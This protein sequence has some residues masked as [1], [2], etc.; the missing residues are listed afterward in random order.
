[1]TSFARN[2]SFVEDEFIKGPDFEDEFDNIAD[3]LNGLFLAGNLSASSKPTI[4]PEGP[5]G[6]VWTDIPGTSKTISVPRPSL[7]LAVATFDP[8]VESNADFSGTLTVDGITHDKAVL[9]APSGAGAA[10]WSVSQSYAIPIGAGSHTLKLQCNRNGG[11]EI[12]NIA[13]TGYTY[14]VIPEPP[15]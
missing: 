3:Y 1:M 8:S 12:F 5:S 14:L 13:N 6:T 7:L 10:R 9:V 4:A 15:E 2:Q 11:A